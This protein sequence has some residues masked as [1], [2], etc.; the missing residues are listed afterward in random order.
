MNP[1]DQTSLYGH[2]NKLL[3]LINFYENKKL[4]NK[5]LLSGYKGIGKSTLAYHLINYILSKDEPFSY[6]IEKNL[7]NTNSRTFKLIQNNSNPNFELID[8]DKDK[9]NIDIF[10][11]RNLI[12][13]LNKSS[14]NNKPRFI[15]IDNIEYLNANS[16][17]ALLK[18]LE[19]T[20][21]NIFFILINNNKK[22]LPTIKSRCLDFKV[23][24]SND[25][26]INVSNKLLNFD[27][28]NHIHN[29]L[30][31]YYMT[32][33][34]IYRLFDFSKENN[35][36]LKNLD[37]QSFLSLMI[38]ESYFKKDQT[39]KVIIHE[40]IEFFLIK[41]FSNIYEDYFNYFLIKMN[42]MK[43]FNLDEESFYLE[44]KSKLLNG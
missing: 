15:L 31:H 32:P 12:K 30:L 38:D 20:E 42:N 34:F 14:F 9:K 21:G 23:S 35:I 18:T 37:L 6:D 16:S 36:D 41:K 3:E 2:Q 19:D 13:I 8:I 17:N 28:N 25:E 11:I 27:I 44:I 24:L 40:F 10:Q 22:I 33:G 7:I 26:A 1:I 43:K 4:P 5:V 39:I 29:E